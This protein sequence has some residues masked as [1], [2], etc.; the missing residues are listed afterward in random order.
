VLQRNSAEVFRLVRLSFSGYAI[1]PKQRK[2][3]IADHRKL[4]NHSTN[5][6][7]VQSTSPSINTSAAGTDDRAVRRDDDDDDVDDAG[8]SYCV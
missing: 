5:L 3:V 8:A 1:T 7:V 6:S 2:S 4:P